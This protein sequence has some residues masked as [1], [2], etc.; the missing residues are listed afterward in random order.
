[1][2]DAICFEI[3]GKLNSTAVLS[4]DELQSSRSELEIIAVLNSL[5]S[6]EIVMFDIIKHDDYVLTAEGDD[7]VLNGSHEFRVFNS[8]PEDGISNK[9]LI[10]KCGPTAKF[11]SAILFKDNLIKKSDNL[12]F[13]NVKTFDDKTKLNLLN[14]SSLESKVRDDYKKRKLITIKKIT[15]YNISKGSKFSTKITKLETDLTLQMVQLK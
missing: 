13:R 10:E 4:S 15:T 6:K 9:G 5:V 2:S 11:G 8:I 14:L 3:L 1:M 12:I 7:I